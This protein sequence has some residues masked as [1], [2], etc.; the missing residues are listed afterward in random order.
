MEQNKDFKIDPNIYGELDCDKGETSNWW[1]MTNYY[2][3][4]VKIMRQLLG[5]KKCSLNQ[6][7][8][9]REQRCYVTNEKQKLLE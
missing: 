2:I 4:G 6:N 9:Q 1:G 8:F 3:Y 5:D 7:K